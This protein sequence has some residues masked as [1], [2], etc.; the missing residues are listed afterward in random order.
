[1]SP[2]P[3]KFPGGP[4][5]STSS[6]RD[7]CSGKERVLMAERDLPHVL[8]VEDE[9][10]ARES[11][12]AILEEHYRVSTAS[13][14]EEALAVLEA[15]EVDVICTD[16]QMPEMNGFELLRK[17]AKTAP[18]TVGVLVT[19]YPEFVS[20]RDDRDEY[21]LVIKPFTPERLLKVVKQAAG[22]SR[23]R[24]LSAT[25]QPPARSGEP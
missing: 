25:T 2:I 22:F 1:M 14:G 7:G 13:G 23:I 24:G 10:L 21:L 6:A 18:R 9:E 19:A 4:A 11:L 3:L 12:A 8:V 15:R 17:A 16:L 5:D 20:N